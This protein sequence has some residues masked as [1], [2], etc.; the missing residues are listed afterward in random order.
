MAAQ[1]GF[2][3]FGS[4]PVAHAVRI[5]LATLLLSLISSGFVSAATSQSGATDDRWTAWLGCWQLAQ[6]GVRDRPERTSAFT[7]NRLEPAA[8]DV[9]DGVLVCVSP[10]DSPAAVKMTTFAG[11]RA[12]LEESIAADGDER[13]LEEPGCHG[14]RRSEWSEDDVRLYTRAEL[15]CDGQPHRTVSALALMARGGTWVDIQAVEVGGRESVRVRRYR[16]AGDQSPAASFLTPELSIKGTAEALLAGATPMGIEDVI[17]ATAKISARALEAALVETRSSFKLDSRRLTALDDG[18][19]ADSV[20]DLMVALSYPERFVVDRPTETEPPLSFLGPSG[21]PWWNETAFSPFFGSLFDPFYYPLWYSDF[22]QYSYAPFGYSSWWRY[23]PYYYGFGPTSIAVLPGDSPA[24]G[25]G[26]AVD[27]RGYTR[28]RPREVPSDERQATRR[29]GSG[30][31]GSSS[32]A[33][34][35]SGGSVSPQGYSGGGSNPG[36]AGSPSGGGGRTAVPRQ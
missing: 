19:V 28:V 31:G 13:Q 25:G 8:A 35:S 20:I 36:S 26:L 29:D 2:P 33:G 32:A 4:P 14:W 10:G 12:V 17:E 7:P 11:G 30:G 9:T 18:G 15:T 23:D 1:S 27:G 22:Y 6:E 16:R 34:G 3:V 21:Y 24:D 5:A